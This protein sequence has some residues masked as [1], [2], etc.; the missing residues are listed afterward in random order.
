MKYELAQNAKIKS[1]TK[2]LYEMQ[3]MLH[4][5]AP[6]TAALISF[7]LSNPQTI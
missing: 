4:A 2:C 6:A 3:I 1:Y 7:S 5:C